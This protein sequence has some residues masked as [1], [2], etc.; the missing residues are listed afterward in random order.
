MYTYLYVMY[1]N[2]CYNILVYYYNYFTTN[3]QLIIVL[4]QMPG[5]YNEQQG[6]PFAF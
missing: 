3:T 4:I 6:Q 5:L 2:T 1:Y